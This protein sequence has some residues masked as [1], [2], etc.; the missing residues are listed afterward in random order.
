[1]R[2]KKKNAGLGYG[3][4]F[5][6]A[7]S[8]KSDAKRKEKQVHGFIREAKIRGEKRF[9]VMSPRKNPRKPRR[10]ASNPVSFDP[11]LGKYTA[12]R[13]DKKFGMVFGSGYTKKEA[14]KNLRNRLRDYRK[15]YPVETQR[16]YGYMEGVKN[17]SELVVLGANPSAWGHGH[18]MSHN[19][20]H[21]EIVLE[22]HTTYTIRTNPS[23]EA[24]RESFTGMPAD[25][26]TTLDVEGMPA[27]D[28]AELGKLLSLYVKPLIGGQVR[29]V[30]FKKPHPLLVSDTSRRQLY[31]V[32]GDQDVSQGLDLFNHAPTPGLC[33]LGEVR[34]IDYK[35][36]KEH[37]PDP[38]LDEWK[39]NFGEENGIKPSLWFNERTKQLSLKGGDYTVRTEGITN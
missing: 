29:E 14:L 5:H 25:E 35:Q 37:L 10:S 33:E 18:E 9:V 4:A 34:R 21:R 8:S 12:H 17:P 3:M 23:A 39:H 26:Y 30:R 6:G 36:R 38:S 20:G 22:P 11:G 27:G 16:G 15:G 31:F 32:G 2:R 1:M 7:F 24:I 13:H 19:P 28:Y